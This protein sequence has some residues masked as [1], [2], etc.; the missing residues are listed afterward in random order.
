VP[1]PY[2]FIFVSTFR[3]WRVSRVDRALAPK[4][5]PFWATR[6]CI[7]IPSQS[8]GRYV[9]AGKGYFSF[10]LHFHCAAVQY[11]L[12]WLI[13]CEN[14]TRCIIPSA[15]CTKFRRFMP[16]SKTPIIHVPNLVP[17]SRGPGI[18][19]W[20][21]HVNQL[22]RSRPAELPSHCSRFFTIADVANL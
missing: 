14:P 8:S 12:A 5:M 6:K 10:S 1:F 17:T 13:H 18:D 16:Q 7:S 3:K 19:S 15:K 11:I 20:P 22:C 4:C 2:L 21:D 9:E